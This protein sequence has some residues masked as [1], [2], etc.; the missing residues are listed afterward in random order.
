[1]PPPP[2]LHPAFAAQI[3]FPSYLHQFFECLPDTYFYAKNLVGQFVMANQR[4]ADLLGAS[5]IEEMIGLT[6]F[7]LCPPDLADQYR[8]EDRRIMTTGQP[9]LN[10]SELVADHRGSLGWYLSS[11]VPLYGDQNQ[12]IGVA[13]AMRDLHKVSA[14]LSPYHELDEAIRYVIRYFD[15]PIKVTELAEITGLSISQFDRRFKQHV[16]MTPQQFI[17]H[18]RMESARRMLVETDKSI[19]SI[20]LACGVSDQSYLTRQFKRHTGMTPTKYRKKYQ[21]SHIDIHAN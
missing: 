4:L 3:S 9:V 14:L 5:S 11:K 16:E 2:V 10:R 13:G 6:D 7:D 15:T 12:I 20:A 17:L 21:Q 8:D 1:M 18:T 19:S